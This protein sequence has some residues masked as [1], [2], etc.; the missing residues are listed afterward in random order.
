MPEFWVR[1]GSA[2][3]K[4]S[5]LHVAWIAGPSFILWHIWLERNRRIF[6]DVRIGV[7]YLWWKIS[8]SLQETIQVKCALDGGVDLADLVICNRLNFHLQDGVA[9]QWYPRVPKQSRQRRKGRVNREGHWTPPLH[10]VL[11]FNIDGSSWGIQALLVLREWLVAV[12]VKLN[13]SSQCIRV[14]T[15]TISWR[16]KPFYML[17]NSVVC[18]DG[19]RL[20]VSLIPKW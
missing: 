5:P 14:T 15:L 10:G 11:K 2:P 6:Q 3:S 9:A 19:T 4:S 16:L 17:W 20:S 12:L 18:G 8:H 7:M 1:L 13:S